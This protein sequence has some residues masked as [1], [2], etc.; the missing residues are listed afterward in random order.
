MPTHQ[1]HPSSF[2]D[3]SGFV[4]ETAG[5]V[6]RQVNSSYAP[7]YDLLIQSGLYKELTENHWLISHEE[8]E[9]KATAS[10]HPYKTLIPQF[11]PFISYPYEWCFEQLQD[12]ALLTLKILRNAID[13]GM[14]LKDATPYNI[15]FLSGKPVFIDTLS[16]EKYHPHKPWIAYRQFCET[17]LY[18]LLTTKY[19][20]LEIHRLFMAYPEGIPAAVAAS[21]LPA[22]ARFSLGNWLHVFL[23]ASVKKGKGKLE[24]G[25]N[26]SKLLRIVDHLENVIKSL[27]SSVVNQSVWNLYYEEEILNEQYLNRK[28][29]L[30]KAMMKESD[31]N[32][33]DLGCN[34]GLFSNLVANSD[35]NIVAA[36]DNAYSI[37]QLYKEVRQNKN[38]ILPL[39]IDLMNP[40]GDAGFGNG[41][42]KAFYQR[43]RFDLCL[44]LALV[45]HICI[46]KNVPFEKL[47]SF[48]A[49]VATSLIIEFI[50]KQDEKVQLLLS[51]RKDIFPNYDQG[52]F[53]SAFNENFIVEDCREIEGSGRIVYRMKIK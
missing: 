37:S 15:Q 32:I 31:Q 35:R 10:P 14:I 48:L 8:T 52:H 33:I 28:K 22:K 46:G 49:R 41:E 21:T 44:S 1:Q 24:T 34:R 2:R 23:P 30:V 50:P 20:G 40:P 38:H 39:C 11:I 43:M 12:A 7:D 6:Y 29:E 9:L 47:A 53:E 19:T 26:K 51:G 25:F 45:H 27:T 16:F 4:F 42:R 13:H 3:P 36:D 17:F 18:P 5:K